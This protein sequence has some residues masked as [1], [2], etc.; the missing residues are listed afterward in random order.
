[1]LKRLLI[2]LFFLLNLFFA[3][4][5]FDSEE[6]AGKIIS[7]FVYDG[8][9][10]PVVYA[11][12]KMENS[13]AYA[14]TNEKG[15]FVIDEEVEGEAYLTITSL[16]F[17][18]MRVK[19]RRGEKRIHITLTPKHNYLNEV[20]ITGTRSERVLKDVPVLTKVIT[21]AELENT[22][23]VTAL[24]ALE[25]IMPGVHFDPSASMGDNIQV[26]GLDNNYVLILVDGERVVP[27]RRESVNFSRLNVAEIER[28]EIIN[29]ASSV[30]YGS[31]AIGSV[32]NIITKEVKKPFEG[33]VQGRYSKYNTWNVD[34]AAGFK[35][36]FLSSKTTFNYKTTKGYD[37]TPETPASYTVN[38]NADISLAQNFGFRFSERFNASLN[39]SYYL[40]NIR[41]PKA[42][43]AATH[44]LDNNYTLGAKANYRFSQKNLLT[45]SAHTDIF[46]SYKVYEKKNDSLGLD[47][48]Y[49]YTTFR[50]VDEWNITDKYQIVGGLEHNDERTF[51]A[52]LFGSEDDG[53]KKKAYNSNAFLQATGTI[54]RNL[55]G[56]LGVRYTYHSG[57]GSHLTPSLSLMYKLSDFRFRAGVNG[58]FKAPTLKEMYY[59]FNMAGMFDIIGN[60]DLESEKS[61]YSFVS[62]EYINENVNASAS[63]SYNRISDKI[64]IVERHILDEN[65]IDKTQM[66][67]QN[68]E[69]VGIIAFDVNIQCHFLTHFQ[70]KASYAFADAKN[71]ETKT[72][73]SGNSKHNLTAA[74]YYKYKWRIGKRQFPFTVALTERYSSPRLYES[75]EIVDGETI[76]TNQNSNDFYC[77][78]LFYTQKIPISGRWNAEIQAGVDNLFD[79]VDDE[80]F[81]SINPGR[82]FSILLRINF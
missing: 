53:Q 2:T 5:R 30:L 65:G 49:Y 36:D 54:F 50:V 23:S 63:F 78:N 11:L 41:N 59:N 4:A 8:E 16:G 64:N 40:H 1:M 27:E 18:D 28:V 14:L 29:G 43:T 37:L 68:I 45:G 12:V 7:G 52:R 33:Y 55:D 81:A 39:G 9:N 61:W 31:N 17:E 32:I 6:D 48:D 66:H 75:E 19:V 15:Y 74:F 80:T 51:S 46:K 72:Q 25:N 70:A 79:Y 58:G 60:P 34:A 24:D 47:G 10:N 71:L 56:V 62:T 13:A 69:N 73:I 38:P 21:A 3:E 44:S 20:V 26:Q 22:G 77:T 76:I 42:S 57:F 67:Y 35:G 82:R